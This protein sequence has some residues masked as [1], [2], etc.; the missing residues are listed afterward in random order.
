MGKKSLVARV[1]M[2]SVAAAE[3]GEG[4]EPV[5]GA[6]SQPTM[7]SDSTSVSFP[8]HTHF[9]QFDD[10]IRSASNEVSA[11]GGQPSRESYRLRIQPAR[12]GF[13]MVGYPIAFAEVRDIQCMY[14][15]KDNVDCLCGALS[16]E[17]G[18]PD[19]QIETVRRTA[20]EKKLQEIGGFSHSATRLFSRAALAQLGMTFHL[21]D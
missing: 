20:L 3:L 19:P 21:P 16:S 11:S 1:L 12:N 15:F 4:A 2:V 5:S 8:P 7:E 10:S 6:R 14:G 9:E 18:L 17:L 13:Q